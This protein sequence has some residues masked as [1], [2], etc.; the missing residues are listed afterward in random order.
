MNAA[1][2]E[3]GV[4]LVGTGYMG[5]AHA[6]AFMNAPPIL[7]VPVRLTLEHLV[8]ASEDRAE[9]AARQWG[10]ARSGTD[11]QA[12][13]EDPA[14]TLVAI[15]APNS[16]HR[17]IALAAAAAGKH[18]YCEKPLAPTGAEAREIGCRRR[19]CRREDPGW[20]PVPRQPGGAVRPETHPSG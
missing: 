3:V 17:S 10:F 15:A 11:W 2:L 12:L 14:V 16:L 1:P 19:R 13:V 5:R 20:L 8:D 7:D 6:I 9:E 18:V 4:G